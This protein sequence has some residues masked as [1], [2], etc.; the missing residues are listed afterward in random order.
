MKKITFKDLEF[1]L[2]IKTDGFMSQWCCKC[3]ARHIWHF[4]VLREKKEKNDEVY[5]DIFRD[6]K[7]EELRRFYDKEIKKP[8]AKENKNK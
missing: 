5:I 7:G 2:T 4:I 8:K 3:G 6:F 1:P